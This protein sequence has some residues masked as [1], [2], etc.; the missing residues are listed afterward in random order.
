VRPSR[1]GHRRVEAFSP[2]PGVVLQ[3]SE[4]RALVTA[5]V[6]DLDRTALEAALM[7]LAVPGI[8]V[9]VAADERGVLWEKAARLAVLSAASIAAGKPVGAL[10]EDPD[11]RPRLQAALGEACAVT[12]RTRWS[13]TPARGRSLLPAG[14]VRRRRTTPPSAGRQTR[15]D[16]RLGG[17]AARRLTGEAADARRA[18]GPPRQASER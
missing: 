13:S 10:R 4:G 1:P 15:R 16:H 11:W 8:E 14:L 6:D 7:P 12:R 5:A 9:V 17:A 18:A 2:D 3:R